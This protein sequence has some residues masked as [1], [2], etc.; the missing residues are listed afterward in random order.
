MNSRKLDS[1]ENP[2]FTQTIFL[3]LVMICFLFRLS[4]LE[5]VF[6]RRDRAVNRDVYAA[7]IGKIPEDRAG[8]HV[9][10]YDHSFVGD[11]AC[12]VLR[13]SGQMQRRPAPTPCNRY[14]SLS[15]VLL[16]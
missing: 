10:V 7:E 2:S 6:R 14:T 13:S 3:G 8:I 4:V 1:E 15:I 5:G 9:V 16:K 11:R 12:F